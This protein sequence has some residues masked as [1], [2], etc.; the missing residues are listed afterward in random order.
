FFATPY[1]VNSQDIYKGGNGDGWAKDSVFQPFD[2]IF[3]GGNG[4][5]WATI[6]LFT[7]NNIY[8]CKE[9]NSSISAQVTGSTYQWQVNTGSGFV[10]ISNGTNYNG[11]STNSLGLINIP[12]SFYGYQYRCLV[13]GTPGP[14]YTLK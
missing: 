3:N 13:N 5:G 10:D 1:L 2:N 8:V 11:A 4:D 6:K 12:S 7:G 9:G 14:V